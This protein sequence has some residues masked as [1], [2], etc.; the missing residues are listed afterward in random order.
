MGLRLDELSDGLAD[1]SV[2]L[3][4]IKA[5]FGGV[6]RTSETEEEPE[7]ALVKVE[8]TK[9]GVEME[10]DLRLEELIVEAVEAELRD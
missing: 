9:L 1:S 4:L 5:I 7:T 3:R 2:D 6:E 10:M 8:L